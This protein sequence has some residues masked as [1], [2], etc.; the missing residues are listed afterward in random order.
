MGHYAAEMQC[1]NCG[2]L[3]GCTCLKAEDRDLD[4]W[5]ILDDWT[6][7][8]K[9]EF[10]N[11]HKSDRD[12]YTAIIAKKYSSRARAMTAAR[13]ALEKLVEEHRADLIRL[14]KILKVERP[15]EK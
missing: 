4:K 10:M 7:I 9:R 6:V 11:T 5:I 2:K 3:R 1:D 12:W 8:T 15:W 14:K 13:I